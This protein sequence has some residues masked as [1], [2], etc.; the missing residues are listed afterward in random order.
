MLLSSARLKTLSEI[1]KD[2][3]QIFFAS[4]FVGPILTGIIDWFLSVFGLLL[5][6]IFWSISLLIIKE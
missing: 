5:S 1:N 2:I 3:G 4:M 6:A